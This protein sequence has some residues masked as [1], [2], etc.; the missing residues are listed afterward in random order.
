MKENLN[1]F[2]GIHKRSNKTKLKE[3]HRNGM[4][5]LKYLQIILASQEGKFD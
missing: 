5:Y 3:L 1:Y 4:F 2:L